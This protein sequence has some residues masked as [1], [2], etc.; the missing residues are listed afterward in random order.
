MG[1]TTM[2]DYFKGGCIRLFSRSS[3]T[4]MCSCF[5]TCIN[6]YYNGIAIVQSKSKKQQL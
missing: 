5:M 2:H 4:A 6:S 1:L 3:W